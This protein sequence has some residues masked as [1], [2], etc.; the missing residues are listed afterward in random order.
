MCVGAV[1]LLPA[2]CRPTCRR[3]ARG[4]A[5]RVWSVCLAH[6]GAALPC[7]LLRFY[8]TFPAPHYCL[9][10]LADSLMLHVTYSLL[11]LLPGHFFFL[12]SFPTPLSPPA[13]PLSRSPWRL[14]VTPG[15]S[16]GWVLVLSWPW[17]AVL[18]RSLTGTDATVLAFPGLL[19]VPAAA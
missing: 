18:A 13:I 3:P 1:C 7:C 11:L 15:C 9:R 4:A 5:E 12:S 14:L 17:A 16:R 10:S 19:A 8:S 6:R 2:S